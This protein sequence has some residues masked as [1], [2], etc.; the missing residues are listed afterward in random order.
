MII[1]TNAAIAV[2]AEITMV[3]IHNS[4]HTLK[5]INH[6]LIHI[7][8]VSCWH[9]RFRISIDVFDFRLN[10]NFA[11][12]NNN[13]I[14]R[15]RKPANVHRQHK[16]VKAK[17]EK[18]KIIIAKMST[19]SFSVPKACKC[20]YSFLFSTCSVW[21]RKETTSM[22]RSRS[23]KLNR[24][25]KQKT[26]STPFPHLPFKNNLYTYVYKNYD[27]ANKLRRTM[28]GRSNLHPASRQIRN[29]QKK[30]KNCHKLDISLPSDRWCS[31]FTSIHSS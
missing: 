30:N 2:A 18:Q 31:R 5:I 17:T 4:Q 9:S 25:S 7:H 16:W 27:W 3:S 28:T 12:N 14:D 29:K 23:E 1:D 8:I 19:N 20:A 21:Q 10:F 22:A 6:W 15:W 24:Y 11:N 13:L 26:E